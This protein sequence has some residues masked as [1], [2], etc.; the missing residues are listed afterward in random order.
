MG[1]VAEMVVPLGEGDVAE[2]DLADD[3]G[4]VGD[5]I[6]ALD[7]TG[8]QPEGVVSSQG[9]AGNIITEGLQVG[10]GHEMGHLVEKRWHDPYAKED[11]VVAIGDG[12]PERFAGVG[13]FIHQDAEGVFV[14]GEP[15]FGHL[16]GEVERSLAGHL[17]DDGIGEFGCG[18]DA[19][20]QGEEIFLPQ[21]DMVNIAPR[22][23][24][25]Q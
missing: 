12:F 13:D 1:A 22:A 14:G 25:G 8:H 20:Q 4:F 11:A 10:I 7:G 19:G 16:L 18:Q 5:G 2:F 24:G 3:G 6:G 21:F 15:D 23:A 17:Q 9:I